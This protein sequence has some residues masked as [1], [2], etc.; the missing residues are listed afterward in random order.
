MAKST[1]KTPKKAAP[2][3]TKDKVGVTEA[4]ATTAPR[5]KFASRGTARPSK[6]WDLALSPKVK[7]LDDDLRRYVEVCAEKLGL[8]PNVIMANALDS[9]RLR[10]F[11]DSYN[12][13]MLGKGCLTKGER[14]MIAVTVSSVNRC[15]YC[16]VA[17]G[18]ALREISNDPGLAEA[19]AFNY[20]AASLTLKHKA[21]LDFVTKLTESPSRMDEKDQK[22]LR[23]VGF[24]DMAI[25]E[26]A[27]V[28]GFFN[29]SNRIAAATGMMPNPEYHTIAR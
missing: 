13:L 1:R 23:K 6:I 24:N 18:A 7:K 22:S 10:I 14:E 3:K 11:I 4:H 12:R 15:F 27:E 2:Q 25:L 16:L 21:M 20:R 5:E 8:V 17:H 19:I 28:A 29:M 9:E 26:I